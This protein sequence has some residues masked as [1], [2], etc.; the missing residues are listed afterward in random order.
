MKHTARV[1]PCPVGWSVEHET[2]PVIIVHSG[3]GN[4]YAQYSLG[5]DSLT[6]TKIC[7]IH[8]IHYFPRILQ[9]IINVFVI[10]VGFRVFNCMEY[11]VCERARA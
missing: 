11:Y 9:I 6:V 1:G 4:E 3:Y 7:T 10:I 5:H 8:F 2:H